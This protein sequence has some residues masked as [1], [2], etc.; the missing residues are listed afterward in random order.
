MTSVMNLRKRWN[1]EPLS[2]RVDEFLVRAFKEGA[3]TEALLAI[4]QDLPYR[5]EVAGGRDLRGLASVTL[6]KMDLSGFDFSHVRSFTLVDCDLTG[7]RFDGVNAPRSRISNKLRGASF[8]SAKLSKTI[9]SWSQ[10]RDCL[11]DGA[12]ITGSSFHDVDLEGSSFRGA[13]CKGV[14]FFGA[15]LVGCDFQDAILD[16]SLFR[17]VRLDASTNLRGASLINVAVDEDRDNAGNLIGRATDLRKA[18]L[19]ETT[20]FGTDPTADARELLHAMERVLR[21]VPATDP[22]AIALKEIISELKADQRKLSSGDWRPEM[23]EKFGKENAK[24]F[25]EIMDEAYRELR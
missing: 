23:Q 16:E 24:F 12:D 6:S 19:D 17:S 5:D 4:L 14:N 2:S 21:H 25:D 11:F 20:R 8:R 18:S 3:R 1:V 7:A 13:V 22:R 15:T 10:A 9:F